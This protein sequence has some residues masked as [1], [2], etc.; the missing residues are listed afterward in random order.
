MD[1]LEKLRESTK[2]TQ[3]EGRLYLVGGIVRDK[4]L[5]L[6]HREDIDIVLE[7]DAV[8]LAHFLFN[9][10]IADHKP[11]VYPRFGTAMVS[12]EGKQVELVSA[13]SE[14]YAPESRKPDVTPAT[15]KDDVLRRDFTINTLMENLHTGEVLDLTGEARSDIENGIIRTPT[16]P[17]ITFEDDPLRMLRAIRFS[18]PVSASQSSKILITRFAK[19]PIDFQSSA[20]NGS[21]MSSLKMLMTQGRARAIENLRVTGLLL[22]FRSRA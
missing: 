7:G 4:I 15:L 18:P 1:S 11:V 8:E 3:Y 6:P 20:R 16:D 13:R 5:G 10:G 12:I 21:E 14:S 2:G 19:K 17:E 9:A 22:E